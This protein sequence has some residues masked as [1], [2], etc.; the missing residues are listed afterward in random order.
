MQPSP[1]APPIQRFPSRSSNRTLIPPSPRSSFSAENEVPFPLMRSS[2]RAVPT[3]IFESRSRS[4]LRTWTLVRID[5]NSSRR[6]PLP[7]PRYKPV[8]VP[9]HNSSSPIAS[10]QLI[11]T[12]GNPALTLIGRPPA[13]RKRPSPRVPSQILRSA[14]SAME[15][16]GETGKTTGAVTFCTSSAIKRNVPCA[17][18]ETS[19]PSLLPFETAVI[20][21]G[22]YQTLSNLPS[23]WRTRSVPSGRIH[24][25]PPESVSICNIE[26]FEGVVIEAKET[27]VK[28]K[29][30]KRIR[31]LS[32][33][34]Q[35][36]PS[37]VCA[38]V[39]TAPP[40]NL[41][42]VHCSRTYCDGRRLVS[43]A[44]APAIRPAST[45]PTRVHR[46]CFNQHITGGTRIC[47]LLLRFRFSG[48]FVLNEIRTK[49]CAPIRP[50]G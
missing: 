24:N 2:P 49:R 29:P 34:I 31:P 7:F 30:S 6:K 9:T 45:N 41:V 44:P 23:F 26:T 3:H 43:I 47:R 17:T 37:A 39:L 42:P 35:R 10:R 33:P 18:S 27:G 38:M 40:G 36:Y 8:S 5:G 50:L 12:S 16:T 21:V 13:K 25:I 32:V 15:I 19:T 28:S 48:G 1:R 14:V 22:P 4:R 20:A 46:V 11:F